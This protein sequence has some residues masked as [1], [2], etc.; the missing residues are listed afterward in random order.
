MTLSLRVGGATTKPTD[1]SPSPV[2]QRYASNSCDTTKITYEFFN[3]LIENF[4]LA[5]VAYAVT[6]VPNDAN[7][8]KKLLDSLRAGGFAFTTSAINT[9]NSNI[10]LGTGKLFFTAD[11]NIEFNDTTNE[12]SLKADNAVANS[13]LNVGTINLDTLNTDVINEK[14][15]NAGVTIE[16][17]LIKDAIINSPQ[18]FRVK[19]L[20]NGTGTPSI[21]DS[22]NVSSITDLGVGLY[23][24]NFTD[25]LA[26]A[27]YVVLAHV[28]IAGGTGRGLIEIPPATRLTNS[29]E[30]LV[31]NFNGDK[32]VLTDAIA[33]DIAII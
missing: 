22:H 23:R 21:S 13:K 16:S 9:S 10:T 33:I 12:F 3:E 15:A 18:V 4:T 26:S 31:T 20:F 8:L 24:V 2:A 32:F 30:V 17:V 25:A 27:P 19:V 11:D 5:Q 28:S 6:N 29:L 1:V 14:T 7:A